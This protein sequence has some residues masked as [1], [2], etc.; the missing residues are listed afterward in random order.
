MVPPVDDLVDEAAPRWAVELT[1][2]VAAVER[3]T[4]ELERHRIVDARNRTLSQR[5]IEAALAQLIDPENPRSLVA[6]V[7]GVYAI[8]D[9]IKG[10][11]RLAGAIVV[12]LAAL[13]SALSIAHSLHWIS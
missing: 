5:R 6:R 10:V 8:F 12:I 3:A 7:D 4:G 2:R 13:A 9:Q 11:V 1:A